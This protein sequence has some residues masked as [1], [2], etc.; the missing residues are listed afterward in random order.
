M[1]GGIDHG[2]R[3]ERGAWLWRPIGRV[4]VG[5][6]RGRT[7]VKIM[8]SLLESVLMYEA[9]VSMGIVHGTGTATNL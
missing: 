6:V 8:E 2:L 4:S 1:V 5:W 3:L 9:E 7:F